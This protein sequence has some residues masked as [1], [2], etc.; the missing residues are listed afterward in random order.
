MFVVEQRNRRILLPLLPFELPYDS[1]LLQHRQIGYVNNKA[2]R[3]AT[4]M[5]K[6]IYFS[7]GRLYL[8]LHFLVSYWCEVDLYL[9][10]M[11]VMHRTPQAGYS[12]LSLDSVVSR[13][14]ISQ[15]NDI[16]LHN[17][18]KAAQILEP[19][20]L[21]LTNI[22]LDTAAVVESKEKPDGKEKKEGRKEKALSRIYKHMQKKIGSLRILPG[23]G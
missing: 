9:Q 21:C 18:P 7:I 5:G 10:F 3:K 1:H 14:W 15:H 2:V 13:D 16:I 22:Q 6:D 17:V 11:P 20:I 12:I 23:Q 19:S 4:E 8:S